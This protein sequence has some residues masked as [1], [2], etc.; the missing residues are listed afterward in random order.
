MAIRATINSIPKSRISINKQDRETVRSVGV[1]GNRLRS[2]L[3]VDAT[4]LDNGETL[5]YDSNTDQFIIK[6]LPRVDGGNF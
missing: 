1:G 3:D 6:D 4:S 2:L 5:V